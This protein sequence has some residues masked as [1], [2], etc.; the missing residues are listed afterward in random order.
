MKKLLYLVMPI[1]LAIMLIILMG[2][3]DPDELAFSYIKEN[4]EVNSSMRGLSFIIIGKTSL[5]ETDIEYEI[6]EELS[7]ETLSSGS[8]PVEDHIFATDT[9][10]VNMKANTGYIVKIKHNNRIIASTPVMIE[11]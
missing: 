3:D 10:S 4:T 2:K 1:I 6:V 8:I 7:N 11:K 5:N 9:S